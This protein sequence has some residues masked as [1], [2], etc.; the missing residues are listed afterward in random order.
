MSRALG[1]ST[2]TELNQDSSCLVVS[3]SLMP[4]FISGVSDCTSPSPAGVKA[5]LP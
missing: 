4:V 1:A 2:Q 5:E 3:G